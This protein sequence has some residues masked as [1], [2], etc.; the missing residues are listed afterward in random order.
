MFPAFRPAGLLPM[1]VRALQQQRFQAQ[2]RASTHAVRARSLQTGRNP[3]AAVP[4]PLI[5]KRLTR[6]LRWRRYRRFLGALVRAD[7][8]AKCLLTRER[9]AELKAQARI[10]AE[11]AGQRRGCPR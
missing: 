8:R 9:I 6:F 2:A 5:M 4:R 10:A 11:A 3:A 1:T 7:R